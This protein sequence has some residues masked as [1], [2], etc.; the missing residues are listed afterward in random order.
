L[1]EIGLDEIIGPLTTG[2]AMPA[3]DR[4]RFEQWLAIPAD[5]LADASPLPLE[6]V[7][8]REDVYRHFAA[9]LFDE[10]IQS[11]N[12]AEE[13]SL[14]VPLGPKAQYPLLADLVN[15]AGLSLS[16]VTFFGMDQWLDWQGRPLPW[17]HPFNLE[18]YFYRH[19]I[20]LL[21]PELRPDTRNVIFPSPLELDY[22]A[23]EMAKRAPVATTYGGFGFQGH[24]AFNE[25]PATRWTQVTVEQLRGSGTRVVPLSVDT[26]IAHAQRSLGGN[27]FGVPPMAV[28]LGMKEL[29]AARRIRLYTEGGAWKQTILRILL[30][31]EPTVDYPVTLVHGHPN[32]AVIVD[33]A[34]AAPPPTDW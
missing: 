23:E 20:D 15:E 2:D 4:E 1:R 27:V 16:H 32:V 11:S 22:P 12:A 3:I 13:L 21:K 25:P 28:T 7:P 33:A 9:S 8:T 17:E 29:L 31:S 19:F 18:G 30:F 34:S 24:L 14:I 26:I 5:E 10:I 6:I